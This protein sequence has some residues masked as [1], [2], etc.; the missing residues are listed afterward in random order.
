VAEI[1]PLTRSDHDAVV[2]LSTNTALQTPSAGYDELQ[3]DLLIRSANDK[4]RSIVFTGIAEGD[5]VSTI[6]ARFASA[7][8]RDSGLRVLLLDAQLRRPAQHNL[9]RLNPADSLLDV[10]S[11]ITPVDSIAPARSEGLYILPGGGVAHDPGAL[12]RSPVFEQLYRT[13]SKSFDYLIIDSPPIREAPETRLLARRADA[14]VLVVNSEATRI[15]EA[16]EAQEQIRNAGGD[17]IGVVLNRVQE[18]IP[19]WLQRWL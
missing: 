18:H 3:T 10:M 9:F 12:F 13:I 1:Q 7:L 16:Q 5:G 14:T 15:R 6:A 17:L 2:A 8:A 19:S 4:V 11:G